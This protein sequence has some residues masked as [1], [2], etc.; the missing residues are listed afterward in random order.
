MVTMKGIGTTLFRNEQ[1]FIYFYQTRQEN[2]Y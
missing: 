2:D 1:E